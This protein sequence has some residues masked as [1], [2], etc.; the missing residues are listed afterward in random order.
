MS[1]VS[2]RRLGLRHEGVFHRRL[3]IAI[4]GGGARSSARR[5]CGWSALDV[6]EVLHHG[7]SIVPQRWLS[8]SAHLLESNSLE[9]LRKRGGVGSRMVRTLPFTP[10][11]LMC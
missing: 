7:C 1:E 6:C 4:E 3:W 11:L 10:F 2:F 5:V 8:S 9:R